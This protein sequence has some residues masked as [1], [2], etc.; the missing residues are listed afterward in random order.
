[1]TSLSSTDLWLL[2]PEIALTGLAL[3]V[4]ILELFVKRRGLIAFVS[5]LGLIIPAVFLTAIVT[6]SGRT[7]HAFYG[8]L[9]VDDY[10]VFFDYLFLLIGAGVI[11]ASYDFVRKY[12]K[13]SGEF[14]SL[15]LFSLVGA[16]F[17]ATSRELITIYIAL[18]LTSFP[19]YIMA[20]MLRRDIPGDP[21]S[22]TRSAEAALKYVL[23]GAMSSAIL[24]Y[25]M[26]LLYGATGSTDLGEIAKALPGIGNGSNSLVLLLADVF[27]FA[28]FGFKI[29]AVPFHMWAP[30]IYQGAPTPGTL[31]F[32]VASKAAGFAA[33]LRVFI[34]GGLVQ[35]SSFYLWGLI[36]LAAALSMTL[37]N[38]VAI[39]QKDIKRMMAYSSIAQAGYILVGFA[40]L[41]YRPQ[42][43]SG[44]AAIL[45]F[46]AV[47][48]IT[49][50]GAFAGI[51]ALANA[52]GGEQISDFNGLVRRSPAL[53]V[54][55]MLCLLSLAGIPPF[56]GAISKII[57]F[58]TAWQE[59]G[60]LPWLVILGLINSVISV[61]YYVGVIYNIF[62]KNPPKDDRLRI[63]PAIS[64]ALAIS[65]LG[66]IA[67]TI[68]IQPLL[69]A[70]NLGAQALI[71]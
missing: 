31:F 48:V 25:G 50:I 45:V 9:S 24:L 16:M 54:G 15:L 70:G 6:S 60:I 56:A 19:L 62:V 29:S 38:I 23:L 7:I 11:L 2:S 4:L 41:A 35:T 64:T 32:S 8:M 5:V 36:A 17:M 3:A 65:V 30:D 40:A 44:N 14:Y 68:F 42:N 66:I 53:A 51:I 10:A 69:N 46:L 61:G 43:H 27:I 47:Y 20:G 13:S 71:H 67:A 12:M 26:A 18:E 37:G 52:T 58:V 28:G 34:D 39:A 21:A 57:I 1:M 22:A 49:N 33:L 63:S 55:M 59:G